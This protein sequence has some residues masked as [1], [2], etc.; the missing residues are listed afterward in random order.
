MEGRTVLLIRHG[1]VDLPAIGTGIP[2]VYGPHQPLNEH[3]IHQ[4]IR[5]TQQL[6]GLGIRADLIYTSQFERAQ[7][8]ANLL[9]ELFPHHPP[10]IPDTRFNGVEAPQWENRPETELGE[11]GGDMFADNPALPALRGETLKH[12]YNRVISE[13]KQVLESH[14]NGT[15]AIV[16]HGEIIDMIMHYHKVG[17][18]GTPGMEHTIDKGEAIILS[19]TNEGTRIEQRVVT[20]EGP[21]VYRERLQ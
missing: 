11:T 3:G 21:V 15:I 19:L 4:T 14:K 8:T 12:C 7:Q 20:P 13:Y 9:H 5:L 18:R 16:T 10:V 6:I 1:T 2:R 17:D